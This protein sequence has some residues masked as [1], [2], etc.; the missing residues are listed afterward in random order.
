MPT[1]VLW[2]YRWKPCDRA[3]I[4]S[5]QGTVEVGR[6][7]LQTILIHCVGCSTPNRAINTLA[8]GVTRM[9]GNVVVC[10]D[11]AAASSGRY[12]RT[13][14]RMCQAYGFAISDL[15]DGTGASDECRWSVRTGPWTF[16]LGRWSAVE[17][18][19]YP[20]EIYVSGLASHRFARG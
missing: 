20:Q 5:L 18:T 6:R 13:C 10:D 9:V 19:N 1:M 4:L 17:V 16:V 14:T 11:G 2:Y 15:N 3:T 8:L 12:Y 7:Y